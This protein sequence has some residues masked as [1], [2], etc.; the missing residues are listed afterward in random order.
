MDSDVIA[1]KVT[2]NRADPEPITIDLAMLRAA[3]QVWGAH[4]ATSTF[5]TV[6]G[7]VIVLEQVIQEQCDTGIAGQ[8]L[9]RQHRCRRHVRGSRPSRA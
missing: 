2:D 6:A 5:D 4:T 7:Q 3:S 8:R 1:I 9:L